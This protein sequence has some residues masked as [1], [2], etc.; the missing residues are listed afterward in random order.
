MAEW[1]LSSNKGLLKT[2]V[3]PE[4]AVL[5]KLLQ[6]THYVHSLI[7]IN[8]QSVFQGPTCVGHTCVTTQN[9]FVYPVPRTHLCI[10]GPTLKVSRTWP[11]N[12]QKKDLAD[13]F[14]SFHFFNFKFLVH[15]QYLDHALRSRRSQYHN[16]LGPH[17]NNIRHSSYSGAWEAWSCS[18]AT[19]SIHMP[20]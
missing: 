2:E 4:R 18:V 5:E 19:A 13:V 10:L 17:L 1:K 6:I 15:K 11:Y 20:C 9:T 3:T 14:F 7:Q 12:K 8:I 16:V